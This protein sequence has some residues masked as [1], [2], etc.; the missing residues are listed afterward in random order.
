ML[1]IAGLVVVVLGL[2][3]TA[4]GRHA[5]AAAV[6]QREAGAS[7]PDA[8]PGLVA[9][10]LLGLLGCVLVGLGGLLLIGATQGM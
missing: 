7:V 10:C 6:A 8:G 1:L 5:G 9:G 4:G 2:A 3:L